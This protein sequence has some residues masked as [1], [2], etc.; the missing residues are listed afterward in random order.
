MNEKGTWVIII[1]IHFFVTDL[2]GLVPVRFIPPKGPGNKLNCLF[3]FF[4]HFYFSLFVRKSA[5]VI[6]IISY[7]DCS[8]LR[9][10]VGAIT[11]AWNPIK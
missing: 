6:I 3:N 8:I 4:L 10:Y 11:L 1:C 5:L 7:L 2:E 9:H